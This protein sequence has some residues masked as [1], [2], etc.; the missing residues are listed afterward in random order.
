MDLL[1]HECPFLIINEIIHELANCLIGSAEIHHVTELKPLGINT[2]Q[3]VL[4]LFSTIQ[5]YKTTVQVQGLKILLQRTT[6]IM[7]KKGKP[8]TLGV[9]LGLICLIR[10]I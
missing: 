2:Y 5:V 1:D 8:R 10:L 4:P 3:R 7:E 9:I 6:R